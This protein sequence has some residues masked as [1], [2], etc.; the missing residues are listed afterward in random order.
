[1]FDTIG[2]TAPETELIALP[3]DAMITLDRDPEAPS[4]AHSGFFPGGVV[5]YVRTLELPASDAE[6]VHR[7]VF[8][9]VY[10]DA[11]VFINDEFAAHSASGYSRFSIDAD[12][13]LRFGDENTIR[14]EARAHRDSRWYTGLG[15]HR[16]VW[17]HYG[18]R[19]HIPVDGVRVTTPDVDVSASLVEV[20][21][22]VRNS[23][24][25]TRTVAVSVVISG[26]DGNT[27]AQ[28]QVPITLV[29][30]ETG[31]VR[32]R[33]YVEGA[34]LWS[35]EQ[36]NLH[37]LRV[38]VEADGLTDEHL[39]TFGIRR[40]QLDS[41]HG[42]RINGETVKLRGACIHHDNGVIGS[43]SIA[44]AEERRVEL[45]KSAGFNAIRSAHHPMSPELL[46]ACD[47]LG[48]LVMDEAF[49]IWTESK[50]PFDYSIVFPERW[51]QDLEEMVAKDFNHPSVVFYS[52]GNEIPE[53]GRPLG[54]RIGRLLAQK[55]HELDPTRFTTN[56]VNPLFAVLDEMP[57]MDPEQAQD[58]NGALAEMV[59]ILD[60]VS[61]SELVSRRTAET[62]GSVDAAGLNYGD[63][64]Y[65]LDRTL[66]PHR[67]II[68]TET[69]NTRIDVNW[70]KVLENDHV[71]GDFTWTGWDY[72]GEAGIGRIEYRNEA[73]F[74][75]STGAFPWLLSSAGDIDITGFRRPASYFRE[76]VFGLRTNPCIAVHR[77]HPRELRPAGGPW[78]WEDV[79]SSWAWDLPPGDP[80]MVTVY[81]GA[82]EV[83]LSLN[84]RSLGTSPAGPAH[85]Y[86][87]AFD[88][89]FE[90]GELVAI[91]R[92]GAKEVGREVL[93]SAEGP[94]RLAAVS[95]RTTIRAADDDLAFITICLE[96]DNGVTCLNADRRFTVEVTGPGVVLGVGSARPETQETFSPEGVQT[97]FDGRALAVIRPTG[98]GD[99]LVTVVAEDCEPAQVRLQAESAP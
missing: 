18:P 76:I 61:S 34:E 75:G 11:M 33:L 8:D 17:L 5:E 43:R 54:A 38:T 4:G 48:M 62:F 49:D 67:V 23:S 63:G 41:R 32:R 21:A 37:H 15:I 98:P 68:G 27:L 40:L 29:P 65:A 6:L 92:S 59:A 93:R 10:R 56:S 42:L 12:P 30:G 97:T 66:F 44:R 35:P 9:G 96:G 36:P 78:S 84:G 19:V 28:E 50:N 7:L 70:P 73:V 95:D 80:L 82:E 46:D 3:H 22:K 57:P 2:G 87:A 90:P 88:V 1:M 94:V 47:R 89:P 99:I 79:V 25:R 81:S 39:E 85:R 26:Q 69:F 31:L 74:P 60:H 52:I 13:F 45:L 77:P 86:R 14:V 20:E 71:I 83:E 24:P 91:A 64:R 72:L 16:N 55:L 53:T 58:G 51:D